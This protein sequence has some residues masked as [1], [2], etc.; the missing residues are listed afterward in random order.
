MNAK[1]TLLTLVSIIILG[2]LIPQRM[3]IPVRGATLHD[4]HEN[5]FWYEPWGSS[6][7]HK[8]IDIFGQVGTGVIAA[9]DGIVIYEGVVKKGG[10]VVVI[11]GPKWRAHYYAHLQSYS[12]RHGQWVRR[13][14]LIGRLGDTGNA[15]GKPAHVHYSILSLLPLPWL[16]STETQGWKKMFYLNPGLA[17]TSD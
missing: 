17:L 9:T 1:S 11:L 5:T 15:Q 14:E 7:V 16:A 10:K 13:G 2:L 12:V 8:G 6:G 3:E 4:W